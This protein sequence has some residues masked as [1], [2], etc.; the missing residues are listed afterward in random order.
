ME[1]LENV[2]DKDIVTTLYKLLRCQKISVDQ[3]NLCRPNKFSK[4]NS[5]LI[6]LLP[7]VCTSCLL[8]DNNGV[9]LYTNAT[10]DIE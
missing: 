7:R 10:Y 4:S 2:F 9:I 1:N 6:F 5:S 3:I 8:C